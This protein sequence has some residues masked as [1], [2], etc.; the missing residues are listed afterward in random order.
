[1]N[2]IKE[3]DNFIIKSD[4]N[5]KYIDD[6]VK[7]IVT[8]EKEILSFFNLKSPY[9]PHDSDSAFFDKTGAAKWLINQT[10]GSVI[11]SNNS[12]ISTLEQQMGSNFVGV[13]NP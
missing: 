12:E 9:D 13:Y 6:V 1:M 2:T 8:K 10:Y 3:L 4:I 7:N 5:I 11:V